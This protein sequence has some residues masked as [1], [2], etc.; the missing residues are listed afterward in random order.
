MVFVSPIKIRRSRQALKE[1]MR[2]GIMTRTKK[3]QL[4]TT[5]QGPNTHR[6]A[7]KY[8]LTDAQLQPAAPRYVSLTQSHIKCPTKQA[9]QDRAIPKELS[10]VRPSRSPQ[11]GRPN[12]VT[13][14]LRADTRL[15]HLES[16]LAVSG[17][18]TA[19]LLELN[20]PLVL[21]K[22]PPKVLDFQG[23]RVKSKNNSLVYM[24][25]AS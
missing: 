24:A 25:Y 4:P 18:Q 8:E 2:G 20:G 23:L 14:E 6:W 3:Q 21:G 15:L 13:L 11:L 19:F 22:R 9:S 16:H 5:N 17:L 1:K 10:A 12:R 7:Q